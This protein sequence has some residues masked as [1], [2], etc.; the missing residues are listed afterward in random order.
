MIFTMAIDKDKGQEFMTDPVV[1]D[2]AGSSQF[3]QNTCITARTAL[4]I[5]TGGESFILNPRESHISGEGEIFNLVV[6][7][8]E[9][10]EFDLTLPIPEPT[11]TKATEVST[12]ADDFGSMIK[13]FLKR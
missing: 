13:D 7:E 3:P 11:T 5:Q 4:R 12:Q 9:I 10:A 8:G 1:I 6:E 2:V